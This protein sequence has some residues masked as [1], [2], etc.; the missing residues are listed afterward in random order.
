MLYLF[1][2][3]FLLI[4]IDQET[5]LNWFGIE[6]PATQEARRALANGYDLNRKIYNPYLNLS[7]TLNLH[8]K[9]THQIHIPTFINLPILI[10]HSNPSI[11]LI[12]N[13]FKCPGQNG[14]YPVSHRTKLLADNLQ[15]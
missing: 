10:R 13:I 5:V 2:L 3:L 4:N 11:K 14:D 7:P 12:R 8:L 9:L 1:R 6:D 15:G